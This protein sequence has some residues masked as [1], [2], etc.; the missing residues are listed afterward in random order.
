[1][2]LNRA[3]RYRLYPNP[4]QAERLE[5]H[6]ELCRQLY[7][8]A[9]W[10]RV[11]AWERASEEEREKLKRRKWL[12]DQTHALVGL[13]ERRP[14]FREMP[15]SA[16]EWVLKRVDLAYRA[17]F[18]RVKAKK[19]EAFGFPKHHPPG[20]YSSLQVMRSRE[21]VFEHGGDDRYGFLSFKSFGIGRGGDPLAVRMHRPLPALPGVAVRRVEIKREAAGRWFVCFGWDAE[22]AEASPGHGRTNGSARVVA[23]HPGLIHYLTT[24]AGETIDAPSAFVSHAR[25]LAKAQRRMAKKKKGSYRY[26]QEKQIVARWHAKIRA[27]RRDFQHNLSRRIVAS[28]DAI[29]INSFD[30]R[31]MLSDGDLDH[32]NLRVADAAW[33]EFLFMLSY[34][35]QA[36]GKVYVEVDSADTVQECSRCGVVVPKTL[37]VRT[38]VCLSCGLKVPRGVNAARNVRKRAEAGV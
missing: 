8:M 13:K 17:F 4:D 1:M 9:L 21:F 32:L 18:R 34:K 31:R 16:P 26:L 24:D 5:R 23:L 27:S 29:Y 2:K 3:Y 6:I 33:G 38:H 36:A 35:A 14:E 15:S 7:N 22:V 28:H 12:K 25:G 30:I 10:W 19:G 20:T 11:G 37:A